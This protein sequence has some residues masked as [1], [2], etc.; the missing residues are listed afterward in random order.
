MNLNA[1]DDIAQLYAAI[2]SWTRDMPWHRSTRAEHFETTYSI[3][4][5]QKVRVYL[6]KNVIKNE[7]AARWEIARQ[8]KSATNTAR[9]FQSKNGGRRSRPGKRVRERERNLRAALVGSED[10][11]Q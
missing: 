7:A 1:P 2:D 5:A 11:R 10:P 8:I 4:G 3:E 9:R 6:A